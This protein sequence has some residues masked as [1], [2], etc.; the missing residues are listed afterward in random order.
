MIFENKRNVLSSIITSMLSNWHHQIPL[1][2]TLFGDE[3]EYLRI[4]KYETINASMLGEDI[5]MHMVDMDGA[6]RT[7]SS[8]V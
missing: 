7:M 4:W 3:I 1:N 2:R 8:F 5:N 6:M